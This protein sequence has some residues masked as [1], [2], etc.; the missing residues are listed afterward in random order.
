[1]SRPQILPPRLP[2]PLEPI[3]PNE[4]EQRLLLST[5][6]NVTP[7]KSS[8]IRC[9]FDHPSH[10]SFAAASPLA[11]TG[12]RGRPLQEV[13]HAENAVHGLLH[14]VQLDAVDL[15]AKLTNPVVDYREWS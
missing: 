6:P 9:S 13:V 3:P 11:L 12:G 15:V 1:M 5:D 10:L 2:G 7:G 8:K 14:A 4:K